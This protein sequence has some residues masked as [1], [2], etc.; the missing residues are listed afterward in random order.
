MVARNTMNETPQANSVYVLCPNCEHP[1]ILRNIASGRAFRCRQCNAGFLV[2]PPTRSN[3][4]SKID[5]PRSS[6][7]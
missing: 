2:R 6:Q 5:D 4:S 3:R 1:A 7:S